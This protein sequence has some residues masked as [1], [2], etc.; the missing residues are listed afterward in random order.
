[1]LAIKKKREADAK[2]KADAEAA[3]AAMD[4]D[5][6]TNT[7]NA[8]TTTS[9]DVNTNTTNGTSTKVS[10][11]GIGGK[12]KVTKGDAA[13]DPTSSNGGKP[14]KKRT[15]GEIRI[16]KGTSH[17]CYVV[18]GMLDCGLCLYRNSNCCRL[19]SFLLEM[20][21]RRERMHP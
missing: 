2:A 14:I 19:V 5:G 3:A 12:K 13:A 1:M 15:P 10:L 16:Q 20:M 8:T 4:V 7:T 11:L 21:F 9:T 6:D 18:V 17:I